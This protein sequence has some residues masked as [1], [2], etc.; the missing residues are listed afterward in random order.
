MMTIMSLLGQQEG[1]VLKCDPAKIK[2]GSRWADPVEDWISRPIYRS[3]PEASFER[4]HQNSPITRDCGQNSRIVD[5][6]ACSI[7]VALYDFASA[8]KE[9]GDCLFDSGC[10]TQR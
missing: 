7:T 9:P 1:L 2:Y 5:G 6:V 10:M 8:T 4:C 3:Q